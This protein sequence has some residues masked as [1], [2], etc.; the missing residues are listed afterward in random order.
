MGFGEMGGGTILQWEEENG[1]E[2]ERETALVWG[3]SLDFSGGKRRGFHRWGLVSLVAWLSG[4][5][6][7]NGEEKVS[8][9][10]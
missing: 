3:V 8:K 9:R 10:Q 1:E 7:S 5:G 2:E 4:D 6:Q